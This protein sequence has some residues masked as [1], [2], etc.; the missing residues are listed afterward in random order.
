MRNLFLIFV[1]IT[2]VLLLREVKGKSQLLV[3]T[4]EKSQLIDFT[5]VVFLPKNL[6]SSEGEVKHKQLELSIAGK[7]Y[8]YKPKYNEFYLEG[9]AQELPV[10]NGDRITITG[11]DSVKLFFAREDEKI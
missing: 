10:K 6:P 8:R 7:I 4:I 3:L 11:T 1:A 9:E 5:G 2:L